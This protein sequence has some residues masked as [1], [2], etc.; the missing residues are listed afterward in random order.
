VTKFI[1]LM[2]LAS[3]LGFVKF[4]GLAYAMPVYEYGRYVAY[5]GVA[6]FASMILSFGITEKTIKDYPR[7][8]VSERRTYVLAD[9]VR[10]GCVL[11]L[12]CLS[13]GLLAL[14]ITSLDS[15]SIEPKIVLFVTGLALC[16]SLLA[17]T[18]SLY[19][20][21]NSQKALQNFSFLRS[22]F[23]AV[24][25]FSAGAAIGWEGAIGGDIVGNA[26]AIGYAM[27]KLPKMYKQ[28]EAVEVDNVTIASSDKGHYKLYLANLSL[29]PQSMLDRMWISHAIGSGMAGAYGVV[30]LIP[31]AAQLLANVIVQY[32]GPLVIKLVHLKQASISRQSSIAFN[33]IL[34]IAFSLVLTLFAL[35]AKQ[36]PYINYIFEKYEISNL[37][38]LIVGIIAC[39]QIYG[40]IEFH[41]IAHNREQ[42][43]LIASLVSSLLFIASF[44]CAAMIEADIEW[45]L[46]GIGAARWGQIWLLKRAYLRYA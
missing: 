31:Q 25:S 33:V 7:L 21:A 9:A 2:L 22:S 32:I 16:T 39:G 23:V 8:W 15:I 14:V 13:V 10:I 24:F 41:L 19:R 30:M 27:W 35:V 36:L 34:M 40:L 4:L 44:S 1:F 42:D 37:S 45:F 3:G 17:L 26:M 18:G 12:R 11:I 43:V 38:I 6:T 46:A 5:F 28:E 20:A 29:A